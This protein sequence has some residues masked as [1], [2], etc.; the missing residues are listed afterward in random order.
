MDG[1]GWFERFS[2]EGLYFPAFMIAFGSLVVLRAASHPV[3][4]EDQI[5]AAP[6]WVRWLIP[7]DMERSQRLGGWTMI[8]LAVFIALLRLRQGR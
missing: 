7:K 5:V 6:K 1:Q 4:T 3:L 2:S 8:G